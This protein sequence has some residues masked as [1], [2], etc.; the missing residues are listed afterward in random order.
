M[1][2]LLFLLSR[3]FVITYGLY[4]DYSGLSNIFS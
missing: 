4:L 1:D 2:T 3:I